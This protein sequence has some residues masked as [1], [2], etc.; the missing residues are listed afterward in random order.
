MCHSFSS[1]ACFADEELQLD[2]DGA[3]VLSETFNILSLKEIKLQAMSAPIESTEGEEPED[4]NMATIVK[5][6]LQVAQ[7]KVVSQV[8]NDCQVMQS[9]IKKKQ[10]NLLISE[11]ISVL[12]R[13]VESLNL[14][15]C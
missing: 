7:K 8:S 14:R 2:A 1:P 15:V 11:Q 5:A 4:E 13:S 10:W 3:E 12:M 6:V 9:L